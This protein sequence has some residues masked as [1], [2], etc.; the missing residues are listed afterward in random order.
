MS[1]RFKPSGAA[2][3]RLDAN[4]KENLTKYGR[5]ICTWV[6]KAEKRKS[7]NEKGGDKQKKQ[8]S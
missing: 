1:K 7:N 8:N 3:R 4:K 2:Y 5:S 6:K